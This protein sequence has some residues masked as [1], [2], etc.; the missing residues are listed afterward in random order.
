MS[1]GVLNMGPDTRHVLQ[2]EVMPL[3]GGFLPLP[4]VRLSRYIPAN[5][6]NYT[7]FSTSVL[8]FASGDKRAVSLPDLC[9]VRL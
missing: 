7:R 8:F 1:P 3:T 6:G 9:S 4:T 5:K 2:L